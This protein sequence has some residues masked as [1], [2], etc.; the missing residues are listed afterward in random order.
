MK[1]TNTKQLVA[2]GFLVTILLS[3]VFIAKAA[4]TSQLSEKEKEKAEWLKVAKDMFDYKIPKGYDIV[5]PPAIG[6]G[7]ETYVSFSLVPKSSKDESQKI[8]VGVY[9]PGWPTMEEQLASNE[10][11]GGKNLGTITINKQVWHR[12]VPAGENVKS[13]EC[14]GAIKADKWYEFCLDSAGKIPSAKL[15]KAYQAFLKSVKIK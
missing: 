11:Y 3:A 4:G 2:F 1:Q 7:G 15:E 6:G 9:L 8:K 5:L 13:Y 10:E 14:H 12:Y